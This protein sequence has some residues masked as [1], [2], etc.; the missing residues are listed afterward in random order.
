MSCIFEMDIP[1]CKGC[2]T[3]RDCWSCDK[4]G[5]WIRD[6]IYIEQQ[7]DLISRSALFKAWDALDKTQDPNLLIDA[8]IRETQDAPAV[9]A[10]DVVRCK[11]CENWTKMHDSAQGKCWLT[12]D[13]PTGSWYCANGRKKCVDETNV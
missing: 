5:D 11:D 9:D 7:G 13:Y 4:I 6:R 2:R 3:R 8:M 10:V 12:G 1:V